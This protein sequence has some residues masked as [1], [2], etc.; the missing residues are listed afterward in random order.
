[1]FLKHRYELGYETLC[2]EV[3]DSLS[4]SRFC[5]VSMGTRVPHPSTLGKITARCGPETIAQLNEALL[6][7]A[8][9]VKVV[10]TDMVRADTTVVAANV[11]Y[12]TDSGLLTRAIGLTMALATMIHLAGGAP[13]TKARDW[14]RAAGRRARSI[15]AH[16]KLRNDEAKARVLAITGELAGLAELTSAEARKVLANDTSGRP[17]TDTSP[18]PPTG[19][20]RAGDRS[21][22]HRA[23]GGP[24]P[25]P[26]RRG[27]ATVG[28]QTGVDARPRRPPDR[29]RPPRQAGRVRLQGPGR[30]QRRRDRARS[31]RA[32]GN[33]AHGPLLVPAVTR[34]Q[35]RLGRAVRAVTTDRGYGEAKIDQE[36]RELGVK[37]VVIPRK[38]KPGAAR[39]EVEHGRGFRRLVKWRTGSEGRISY[40]KRRYGLDRT[41]F[42]NMAGAQTWCGLG[43]LAHNTVKIADLSRPSRPEHS[44]LPSRTSRPRATPAVGSGPSRDPTTPRAVVRPPRSL[45]RSPADPARPDGDLPSPGGP[46]IKG[47]RPRRAGHRRSTALHAGFIHRRRRSTPGPHRP[48]SGRSS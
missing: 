25:L 32:P 33:P 47:L 48:I 29:Q 18:R 42:D 19:G 38:G 30:R 5:R 39:R 34:I 28:E 31:Q 4:W 15:S 2:R 41:L 11:T 12:P 7:K 9:A 8:G 43:V 17:P 35:A 40:L 45:T 6:V 24:D 22:P 46:P 27:H 10:R 1:M 3:T 37:T 36:L 13:R 14:R 44:H 16:L 23:G 20:R 26:P 21:R